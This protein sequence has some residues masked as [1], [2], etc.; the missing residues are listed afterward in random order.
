MNFLKLRKWDIREFCIFEARGVSECHKSISYNTE[1][2]PLQL[3][4]TFYLFLTRI[5]LSCL[6]SLHKFSLPL[7]SRGK[8]YTMKKEIERETIQF[9]LTLQELRHILHTKF[10]SRYSRDYFRK[11]RRMIHKTDGSI[12]MTAIVVENEFMRKR[13]IEDH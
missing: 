9:M 2:Y 4:P 8:K 10:Y 11:S 3:L 5:T 6:Y 7:E 12:K 1:V 13:E